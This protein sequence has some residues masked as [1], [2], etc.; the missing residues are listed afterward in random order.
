M[1][2]PSESKNT[3]P[4]I[5]KKEQRI[6]GA[7]QRIADWRDEDKPE[8]IVSGLAY[9]AHLCAVLRDLG[10]ENAEDCLVAGVDRRIACG[11]E[12]LDITGLAFSGKLLTAIEAS[13]AE[14]VQKTNEN[15]EQAKLEAAKRD[16]LGDPK[17]GPVARP[18]RRQSM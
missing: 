14:V 7:K 6:A 11:L 18:N 8:D 9:R 10:I 16:Q 1:T 17:N 2:E 3:V 15:R 13:N 12:E 5:S 4:K